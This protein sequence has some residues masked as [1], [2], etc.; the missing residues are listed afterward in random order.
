MNTI[1]IK[2]E[3]L[4]Y[5]IEQIKNMVNKI[6]KDDNGNNVKIIAVIKQNAYGLGLIEYAKFLEENGISFFAVE[7][8]QEAIAIRKAGI[9]H[10]IMV[11]N[12]SAIKE[13]IEL[14]VKNNIIITI[15]SKE[16]AQIANQVGKEQKIKVRAHININTGSGIEGFDY[17]KKEEIIET[18]KTTQNIKIEGTFSRFYDS[19]NNEKY[20]KIQFERFINVIEILKMNEIEPGILHICDGT[21]FFR[22]N[23]MN[24]NAIRI[25]EE[26]LG[27]VTKINSIKLREVAYLETKIA[28]IKQ[29]PKGFYIGNENKLRTKKDITIAIIPYGYEEEKNNK[30]EKYILKS[31]DKIKYMMYNI[32]KVFK[33]EHRYIKINQKKCKIIGKIGNNIICDVSSKNIKVGEKIMFP[34]KHTNNSLYVRRE[35]R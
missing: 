27:R 29:I 28:Q 9:K 12:S 19:A 3:N 1:I 25:G 11:I 5:N 14:L 4:K 24:L 18:I 21:A 10:E 32:K 23:N 33:E 30:I 35:Y 8:I 26:F 34:I 13:D 15:S 7:T 17:T 2:K 31:V 16:D 22:F 20:T 6:G